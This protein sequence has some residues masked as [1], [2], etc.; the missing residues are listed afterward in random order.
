M[1]LVDTGATSCA[2]SPKIVKNLELQAYEKRLIFVAT[3]QRFVDYYFF[4]IGLFAE[5]APSV[6]I[7][8]PFIIAECDGF[9]MQS[10][11]DFDVILGMDVLSQCDLQVNRNREWLLHFG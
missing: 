7:P 8:L 11:P 10:A 2:I 5:T 1:A 6:T 4:R 9:G 3:E